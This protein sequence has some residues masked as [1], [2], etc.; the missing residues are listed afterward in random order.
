MSNF[1]QIDSG[2][3]LSSVAKTTSPGGFSK[4]PSQELSTTVPLDELDSAS[5]LNGTENFLVYKLDQ[6]QQSNPGSHDEID[7]MA[8]LSRHY[9]SV[10]RLDKSM[11]CLGS[12]IICAQKLYGKNHPVVAE[13][14]VES[15]F[16]AFK[17]KSYD[18]ALEFLAPAVDIYER[19]YGKVSDQVAFAFHKLGK[20]YEA[21]NQ[22]DRAEQ[23][24]QKAETTYQNTFNED[25]SEI[26]I[27][28][29]DLARVRAQK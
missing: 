28:R 24:Y 3:F 25:D 8:R 13:L 19:S 17:V 11:D 9:I 20:V 14:L 27:V 1:N 22:L 4:T 23:Y 26:F 21:V 2:T 7:I 6:V 10:D 12:A 16:V 5:R 29:N 15:A 18:N